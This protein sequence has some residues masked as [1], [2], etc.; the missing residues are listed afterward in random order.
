[1]ANLSETDNYEEGVYQIELTDP[2]VGGPGGI[3]NRQ[4]QQ[5]ANRTA[6][7]KKAIADAQNA[8]D[9]ANTA[10]GDL[11]IADISGL[12]NA[13]DAA[14]AAIGDLAIADIPGL[15]NAL[16]AANAAIG[17]L[18]VAD[19]SGLQ[20]ALANKEPAFTKRS[21]FNKGFGIGSNEVARGNHGHNTVG[22]LQS[23][24]VVVGAGAT[25]EF[26]NL[27]I[28][29]RAVLIANR[30]ISSNGNYPGI[31]LLSFDVHG[32]VY[33]NG[34]VQTLGSGESIRVGHVVHASRGAPTPPPNSGCV[35]RDGASVK[36]TNGSSVSR[37]FHLII[38]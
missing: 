3:A 24:S 21:A 7:L 10:I 6:W 38:L 1:M 5:L 35:Y 17:D 34:V 23:L 9:A 31:S 14:N 22:N 27:G 4:A 29:L 30:G 13:L 33:M 11:A 2:V 32:R 8:L 18:A 28:G 20:N 36:I 12:Q 26:D 15:Q 16:D 19:I 37:S 25:M